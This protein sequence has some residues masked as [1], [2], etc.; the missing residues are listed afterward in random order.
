MFSRSLIVWKIILV[1]KILFLSLYVL[2][3]F[4][5]LRAQVAMLHILVKPLGS[6]FDN[7]FLRICAVLIF[8]I[9]ARL[10]FTWICSKY[11]FVPFLLYQELPQLLVSMLVLGATFVLFRFPSPCIL[12]S[13]PNS[14]DD[15]F[16]AIGN[17]SSTSIQELFLWSLIVISGL[18]ASIFLS[19]CIAKSQK[20]VAFSAS[21]AGFS[22]YGMRLCNV[23]R[24]SNRCIDRLSCLFLYS[25]GLPDSRELSNLQFHHIDYTFYIRDQS[26]FLSFWLGNFWCKGFDLTQPWKILLFQ[27]SD[28]HYEAADECILD[29]HQL[30]EFAVGIGHA[31]GLFSQVSFICLR[32]T[33]LAFLFISFACSAQVV[34]SFVWS[35]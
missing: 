29:Q 21:T 28:P 24:S 13:F 1:S 16:S 25:V 35:C 6:A 8:R 10:S 27:L 34:V 33:L 31:R 2:T 4:M 17:I 30:V 9:S 26:H 32:S 5:I 15:K 7:S 11:S 3:R 19:V 23:G 20:I 14:T 12:I 22:F 18:L